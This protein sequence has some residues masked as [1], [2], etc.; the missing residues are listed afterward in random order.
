MHSTSCR[1]LFSARHVATSGLSTMQLVTALP[2]TMALSVWKLVLTTTTKMAVTA[3]CVMSCVWVGA[4][5][6]G[7]LLAKEDA[8]RVL[9]STLIR[10]THRCVCVV[11]CAFVLFCACVC[12]FWWCMSEGWMSVSLYTISRAPLMYHFMAFPPDILCCTMPRQ[13]LQT[14]VGASHRT[15]PCIKR[16]LPPLP[17]PLQHMLWS[18]EHRVL[19]MQVCYF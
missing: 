1:A 2:A 7:I 18:S 5:G 14:S 11:C 15:R 10:T 9:L 16:G 13:H 12:A 6:Q 3:N 4:Q 8:M 17:R 19:H